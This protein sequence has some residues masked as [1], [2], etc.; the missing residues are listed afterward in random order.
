MEETI[1]YLDSPHQD[2]VE[3]VVP[4]KE[5]VLKASQSAVDKL[6]EERAEQDRRVA[7]EGAR[8]QAFLTLL[9]Q[10]KKKMPLVFSLKDFELN[11]YSPLYN[12]IKEY[13]PEDFFKRRSGPEYGFRIRTEKEE[14]NELFVIEA[15]TKKNGYTV[16]VY[17]IV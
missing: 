6:N 10:N 16:E 4:E 12:G 17:H 13:I 3:F 8:Y 1:P 9:S 15:Y 5:I 2:I 7:E 14:K 11:K